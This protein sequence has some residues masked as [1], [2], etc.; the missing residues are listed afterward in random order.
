M[1]KFTLQKVDSTGIRLGNIKISEYEKE[2][3][4]PTRAMNNADFTHISELQSAEIIKNNI[5]DIPNRVVEVSVPF[6]NKKLSSLEYGPATTKIVDKLFK[7]TL[8]QTKA[9]L[10]SPTFS[11]SAKITTKQNKILLDIQQQAGF[12]ALT[13]I[14]DP[15]SNITEFTKR[16]YDSNEQIDKY[17]EKTGRLVQLDLSMNRNL[18][19]QKI[20]KVLDMGLDGIIF[21]YATF[22]LKIENYYAISKLLG[23][24]NIFLHISGVRK[25][26]KGPRMKGSVYLPQMMPLFGFDSV[27]SFSVGFGYPEKQVIFGKAKRFDV[28]TYGFLPLENIYKDPN[29]L[30]NCNCPVDMG[31]SYNDFI[32]I[33]RMNDTIKNANNI[34]DLIT[35]YREFQLEAFKIKMN[36]KL[37]FLNKKE[38]VK[39]FINTHKIEQ[40]TLV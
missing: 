3:I 33:N 24:E 23:N 29:M 32:N 1:F 26:Y 7:Y 34:H 16:L 14:D 31:R 22:R 36:E 37:D 35:S 25:S 20:N 38:Y 40:T 30:M 8:D 39:Q 6:W 2:I 27:A 4:T 17:G 12:K 19:S 21:K 15:D 28:S 10:F 13:I 11:R 5:E 9:S 18:L